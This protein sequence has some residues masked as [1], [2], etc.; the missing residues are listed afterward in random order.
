MP[1]YDETPE[2]DLLAIALDPRISAP[3]RPGQFIPN[4][5]TFADGSTMSRSAAEVLG[6]LR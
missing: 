4:G 5:L 6:Y 3:E 1:N 2:L